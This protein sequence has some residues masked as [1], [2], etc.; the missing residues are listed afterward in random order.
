MDR[1]APRLNPRGAFLMRQI[2]RDLLFLHWEADPIELRRL[3][4]PGLE[5]DTYQSRAY[6]GLVP[7][8]MPQIM[9]RPPLSI[10]LANGVQEVN[11]RTYVHR[12]GRDP[13][14]WFLS[15]D[16]SSLPAVLGAR[17]AF[18]LPYFLARFH[19]T[20]QDNG[21][22]RY[23][24]ERIGPNPKPAG[25]DIIYSREGLASPAEPGSLAYFLIERY[26]LY[27][28]HRGRLYAASVHHD[29]YPV[30]RAV[31]SHLQET[32]LAA[33]G[34]SHAGDPIAHYARMVDVQIHSLRRLCSGEITKA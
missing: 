4:P 9:V 28:S 25:C 5:L 11:V 24:S 14:V 15:L 29:P 20:R 19:V 2:W 22:I 26:T 33:S 7:F 17:I 18:K 30:Q 16:A 31:V 21:A 13:G 34:V 6:I 23:L 10:P 3:L 32:L 8:T 27:A 1:E 12:Q